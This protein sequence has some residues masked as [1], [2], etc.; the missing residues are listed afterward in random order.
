MLRDDDAVTSESHSLSDTSRA[1]QSTGLYQ[2]PVFIFV[3]T[4]MFPHT[5]ALVCRPGRKVIQRGADS[6]RRRTDGAASA[7]KGRTDVGRTSVFCKSGRWS[8]DASNLLSH[9]SPQ[10]V[11][12]S[13]PEHRTRDGK[14]LV[15]PE[16]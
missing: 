9:L 11:S 15:S 4:Q 8:A 16:S 12:D 5:A 2:K 13:D 7:L 14:D 3:P 1:V 10:Y 6:L